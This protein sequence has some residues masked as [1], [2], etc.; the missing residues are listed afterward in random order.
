MNREVF[1][2][3]SSVDRAIAE[4]V[5]SALESNGIEC[6]IAPRDIVP[7]TDWGEAIIDAINQCRVMVLIFSSRANASTQIKREVERAV[8]K[9][10]KVIPL[11]IEDVVPAKALE[12]FIGS[13]QWFDALTVPVEGHLSD[14]VQTVTNALT[15]SDSSSEFQNVLKAGPRF[16][17]RKKNPR[18]TVTLALTTLIVFGSLTFGLLKIYGYIQDYFDVPGAFQD[19]KKL[20]LASDYYQDGLRQFGTGN[21]QQAIAY[22]DKAIQL[23]PRYADAYNNRG[24]AY[25]RLGQHQEAIQN[26][27]QVIQIN[28]NDPKAYNN[29]GQEFGN[30][31]Q[32][33]RAFEDYSKAIAIDPKYADAYANRGEVYR[34]RGE[35][36]KAI[37][38][39][40]QAVKNNPTHTKAYY[41]RAQSY[42]KLN[43]FDQA[44]VDFSKVIQLK[45][46]YNP[47]YSNRG[48]AYYKKGDSD[49]AIQDYD[50]AITLGSKDATVYNNRG[51]AFK[52]K[53]KFDQAVSDFTKAIGLDPNYAIAYGNRGI[54]LQKQ[55]KTAQAQKDLQ[56][57]Q[58]LDPSLK[59]WA[60]KELQE[61]VKKE[62]KGWLKKLGKKIK[63][64]F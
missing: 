24:L 3:Y 49:K 44:I 20:T 34:S 18:R 58:T 11:R 36:D 12:Y 15:T 53:G 41:G 7:G 51:L 52:S 6:W 48:W 47:A 42:N 10:V 40:D 55:G 13:V 50:Q 23:Q 59:S 64:I 8:N 60:Q 2:S 26:F 21:Y 1:I 14:L 39:F 30:T 57:A 19:K 61:I 35:D 38:D 54:V 9:G 37:P 56:K 62:S 4:V 16:V 31:G 46:D 29:R 63:K 5:C 22:F 28:P 17:E 27:N 33:N 32:Q 43:R 45:P 25:S